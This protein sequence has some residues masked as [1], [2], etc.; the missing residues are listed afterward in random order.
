M[1]YDATTVGLWSVAV[2]TYDKINISI[3]NL[4]NDK[5]V[6]TVKYCCFI[7]FVSNSVTDLGIC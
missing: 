5:I 7:D 4:Q 1:N 6:L 2:L 3:L